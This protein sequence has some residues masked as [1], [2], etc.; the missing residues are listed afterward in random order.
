MSNIPDLMVALLLAVVALAPAAPALA[1][2]DDDDPPLIPGI[3]E[4]AQAVA[5]AGPRWAGQTTPWPDPVARPRPAG[6][7]RSTWRPVAVHPASGVSAATAIHALSALESAYDLLRAMGWHTP[8]PDGGRGGTSGLDLYLVAD[9]AHRAD[10]HTDASIPWF[11]LDAATAYAT[12]DAAVEPDAL[13]ACV[14]EAYAQALL[15]RHDPAEAQPWR[16]ATATYL[17]TLA[18][19]RT[20]DDAIAAQQA[21]PWRPWIGDASDDPRAR[22][23][24]DGSGGAVTLALLCAR[25]DGNRGSF[26]RDLW[27]LAGQKSWTPVVL[28]GSPDLWEALNRATEVAAD[29]LKGI[30]EDIS[31][32]RWF[33]A[34][35]PPTLAR[36]RWADLPRYTAAS[37]ELHPYGSGFAII[38]VADAPRGSQL[39]VWLRGEYG[40]EWALVGVR[41]GPDGQ[42]RGRMAAPP[43]RE[44]RS[45]VPIDLNDD[46]TTV[47]VAVTNLSSRLPDA[48][49]VDE[50]VRAFRLILDRGTGEE[51]E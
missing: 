50:N 4:W 42:E 2:D 29:P 40:V 3:D 35:E 27:G 48:D 31:V 22:A 7:L 24:F 14:F 28:H 12:V 46:T 37:E 44:P 6:V 9:P 15:F 17:A 26:L 41:L 38:D 32:Q 21:E 39:R 51:P 45:Y 47:L 33:V 8:L 10:A 34:P 20:C 13:P 5:A 36:L 1:Q 19:G 16:R 25:A 11:H 43:R 23:A 49:S 18:L 30:V